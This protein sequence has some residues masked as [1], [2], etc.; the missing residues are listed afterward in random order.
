MNLSD[1]SATFFGIQL[2]VQLS[3]DVTKSQTAPAGLF[4][5][6]RRDDPTLA[7]YFELAGISK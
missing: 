5:I 2:Y 3:V 4:R 7:R 6:V 1:K